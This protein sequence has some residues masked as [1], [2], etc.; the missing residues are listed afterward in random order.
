MELPGPVI[1]LLRSAGV[2]ELLPALRLWSYAT[3]WLKLL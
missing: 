1:G 3:E 2:P